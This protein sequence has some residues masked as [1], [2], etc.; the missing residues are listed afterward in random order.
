[1]TD[2]PIDQIVRRLGRQPGLRLLS[3]R[4][5]GLPFWEVP[6]RCR[7]LQHTDLPV[8][9]E[10]VLLCINSDL[11]QS[12][13]IAAFLGLPERV[14]EP[15]MVE[16]LRAGTIVP[17]MGD[18]ARVMYRV[19]ERGHRIL[20]DQSDVK[21]IEPTVQLAY[22]G[23][24]RRFDMVDFADRWRPR[25][26]KNSEVVEL[27]PS[28]V[29]PPDVGPDDTA[30]VRPI[31]THVSTVS[32]FE[33]IS[34]LGIGGKR[35]RFFKKAIA[36]VFESSDSV[37]EISVQIAVDGR[38]VSDYTNAFAS[39]NGK[40]RVGIFDIL[41]NDDREVR[42]LLGSQVVE[43]VAPEEN[44]SALKRATENLQ[45]EL[46]SITKGKQS[47]VDVERVESV[48]S[49]LDR[50]EAALAAMPVRIMEVHEHAPLLRESLDTTTTRLLIVSPWIKSTI[51]NDSFMTKLTGLLESG[52][53]VL[54]GYGIND[55][56][57][58]WGDDKAAEEKLARLADGR[59][60]FSFS[61]LGNTHAKI[62]AVD[63]RFVVVT[64]FNWLSFS[65]DPKRP[66][67]DERGTFVSIPT[68]IDRIYDDYRSRIIG[69]QHC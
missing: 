27:K 55:G 20:Q 67:R 59:P 44:V 69:D 24:L 1:M 66:F 6:V 43:Q 22:D 7:M 42:A 56:K 65:G 53:E 28:P 10:F 23:L 62:L 48:R 63:S 2:S 5:V 37:G 4:E 41:P 30:G 47:E 29:D 17:I 34:V 51:V 25:D 26:L 35:S 45:Q 32:G 19:T 50:A 68:E 38:L 64:S 3:Y 13:E 16:C 52:V 39:A 54:I 61:R 15:V 49:E 46:L 8:V 40:N 21:K 36:M 18:G 58:A 14:I 57:K 33:L 11:A 9:T 60:N 12:S 31:L